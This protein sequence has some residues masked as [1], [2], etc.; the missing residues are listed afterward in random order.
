MPFVQ[1][2]MLWGLLAVSLPLI[3]HLLNRLRYRSVKWAAIMFLVSATKSSTRRA[4]LRQYLV[5]LARMLVVLLLVLALARPIVGGWFGM[6]LAGAPD[7]VIVLL[8][9]SASMEAVDPRRQVS[10]RAYS[11]RLFSQ[12]MDEAAGSSRF[13]LVENALKKPQEIAGLSR[14][15]S[16]SLAEPTDTG[17]NI[18]A[19]LRTALDYMLKNRPGRSEIWLA[20]DLQKSNWHPDSSEWQDLSAQL[21]ALPQNVRLRILSLT[22]PCRRNSSVSLRDARRHTTSNRSHVRLAMEINS[23]IVEGSKLPVTIHLDGVRSQEDLSVS[24]Q[25]Q[26]YNKMLTLTRDRAEGGW[27]KVELPA[28]ENTRDNSCYFM[29]PADLKLKAS[30]VADNATV[31]SYLSLATV[32][33]PELFNQRCSIVR[34]V[35][36]DT[37]E[38]GE[39][40]LLL[41]QGTQPAARTRALIESFVKSGGR[42]VLFP[43]DNDRADSGVGDDPLFGMRWGDAENSEADRPFLV[44]SW[45]ENEG[46]LAKTADGSDLPVSDLEVYRR[47][48]AIMESE[49]QASDW[50]ALATYSDGKPF[51]MR[52]VVGRGVVLACTSSP[53]VRWSNLS[54]GKGSASGPLV[55]VPMLQR[56]LWAGSVRLTKAESGTCGEWLPGEGEIWTSVDVSEEKDPRWNAGVYQC[57]S[58]LVALNRPLAEDMYEVL[59]GNDVEQL[60]PGLDV[61]VLDRLVGSSGEALRSEIWKLFLY[62]CLAFMLIETGLL[63]SQGTRRQTGPEKASHQVHQS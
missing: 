53:D 45:E 4:R 5:L 18:P 55:L 43:P 1:P 51:L 32:P 28:D 8:D 24:R 35:D 16:M 29:Y 60:L 26:R 57:G 48:D 11:L 58:R 22:A 63:V 21:A 7:T 62:C 50:H 36:A 52:R 40:S 30:V 37:I 13:V 20:S 3:I 34:R 6:T 10:K 46:P 15:A 31:G 39:L 49:D 2:F 42:V 9:R 17:A 33:D 12:A 38:W 44:A 23:C 61:Q 14:L 59:S 56:V 19:M 27:G 41:W 54:G 47:R 25:S